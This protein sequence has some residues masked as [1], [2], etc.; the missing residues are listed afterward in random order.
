MKRAVLP[1]VVLG[2][3]AVIYVVL[4]GIGLVPL[5]GQCIDEVRKSVRTQTASFDIVETDCDTLAKEATISI[6][7]TSVNGK[8]HALILSID[9]GSDD[10]PGIA[11]V[12]SDRIAI[13]V[14]GAS[15]VHTRRDVWKDIHFDYSFAPR[16]RP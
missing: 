9:P 2:G 12:S 4:G 6:Y 11:A 1:I 8:D 7:A 3:I 16:P 13:T 10:L 5:P 15:Y 14:P